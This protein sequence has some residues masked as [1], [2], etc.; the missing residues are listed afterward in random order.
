MESGALPFPASGIVPS[1]TT[2]LPTIV[3]ALDPEA[4]SGT[5]C[6]RSL[7]PE[8]VNVAPPFVT[9]TVPATTAL[10]SF[11]VNPFLAMASFSCFSVVVLPGFIFTAASPFSKL[12]VTESTP[13]TALNDTRTA[14]AQTS[15]SM[16]KIVM[17]IDLIS[18]DAESASIT[19]S[20]RTAV[21]FFI[22]AS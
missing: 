2:V 5:S 8:T 10:E 7:D 3:E 18:A 15:Q 20:D 6:N 1:T 22:S 19:S 4:D 16:P 11:I 14:C 12:T 13:G 21:A 9:A 17:S